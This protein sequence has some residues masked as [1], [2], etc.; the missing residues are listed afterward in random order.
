M[1]RSAIT[2]GF[3]VFCAASASSFAQPAQYVIVQSERPAA[4][5]AAIAASGGDVVS[6]PDLLPSH[7]MARLT[8]EQ[9]ARVAGATGATGATVFPASGRLARGERAPA[10]AALSSNGLPVA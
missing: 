10:C 9:Q 6:H 7:V 5:R 4:V 3:F 1:Y 2:L 8:P